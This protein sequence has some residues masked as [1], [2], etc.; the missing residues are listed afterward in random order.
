MF[1]AL[2]YTSLKSLK[3]CAAPRLCA[4]GGQCGR[5]DRD[6]WAVKQTS[7][8]KDLRRP[9]GLLTQERHNLTAHLPAAGR[10]FGEIDSKF[11]L[12]EEDVESPAAARSTG[13]NQPQQPRSRNSTA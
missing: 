1:Y 8:W 13:V 2:P 7:T 10:Q 11:S 4:T 3:V 6:F 5:N 9:P 12:G